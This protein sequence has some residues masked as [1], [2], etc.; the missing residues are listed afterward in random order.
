MNLV[1]WRKRPEAGSMWA[2]RFMEIFAITF[3]RAAVFVLL[4][5]VVLYFALVRADER[6]ASQDFLARVYR[7]KPKWHEIFAQFMTFARVT[8]DRV[9]IMSGRTSNIRIRYFGTEPLVDLVQDAKGGVFLAAHFGSFE[10]ARMVAVEHPQVQ[11]RIVVDDEINP[12]FMRRMAEIDPEFILSIISPHQ[13]AASLGVEIA[14]AMRESQWVGF[15]ADRVFDSDRVIEV[16]FLD[17]KA[18]L[19]AGPFM[20]AAAFKAPVIAIFPIFVDGGYDVHCEVLTTGL[21]ISRKDRQ[22]DIQLFAQRYMDCLE[23]YVKRAPDNWLNFYDY[24]I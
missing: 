8:T 13:S 24:F 15:L 18:R 23:K 3:G 1:G 14:A 17:G 9:F 5:P 12:N 6:R 20:V 11:M 22:Q 2:I 4:Y 7:R 19:P 16:D 21:K 10:A